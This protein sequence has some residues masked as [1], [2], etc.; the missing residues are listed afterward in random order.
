MAVVVAAV[1][2]LKTNL[3]SLLTTQRSLEQAKADKTEVEQLRREN[4]YLKKQI[5]SLNE[6]KAYLC[7]REKKATFCNSTRQPANQVP[8]R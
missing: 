1:K 2:E 5:Q 3:D 8:V 4:E 7:D 6:M